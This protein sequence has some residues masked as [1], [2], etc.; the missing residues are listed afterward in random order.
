MASEFVA[1]EF[2]MERS[3]AAEPFYCARCERDKKAKAKATSTKPDGT[4]VTICNGC[5]GN[6]KAR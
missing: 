3:A 6:I 4:V 2:T 1:A 5:Y